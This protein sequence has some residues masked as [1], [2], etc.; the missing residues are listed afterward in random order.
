MAKPKLATAVSS[1]GLPVSST[2]IEK[3][4]KSFG[5]KGFS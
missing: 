4:L 2:G 1:P 5:L 3:A